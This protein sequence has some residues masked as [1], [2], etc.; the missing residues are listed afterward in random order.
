MKSLGSPVLN[1]PRVRQMRR[2]GRRGLVRM[3]VDT[4]CGSRWLVKDRDNLRKLL[5]VRIGGACSLHS[6]LEC[7]GRGLRKKKKSTIINKHEILLL[8]KFWGFF[9]NADVH[10]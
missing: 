10:A 4:G 7:S 6:R 3:V 5:R 2:I 8:G 1:F 9:S